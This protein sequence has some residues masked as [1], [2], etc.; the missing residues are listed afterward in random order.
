MTAD[1]IAALPRTRADADSHTSGRAV[2]MSASLP[3]SSRPR[4]GR[5]GSA[6]VSR[7]VIGRVGETGAEPAD[8][9]RQLLAELLPRRVNAGE[10]LTR[11]LG[12]P[13]DRDHFA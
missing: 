11:G 9:R 13:G 1:A 5:S 3:L 10:P 7:D 4:P 12:L 6:D 2:L 8:D